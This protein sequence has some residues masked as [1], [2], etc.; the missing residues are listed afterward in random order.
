MV[1]GHQLGPVYGPLFPEPEE[2]ALTGNI[3]ASF[4]GCLAHSL[5][6]EVGQI[7]ILL[8]QEGVEAR[9]RGEDSLEVPG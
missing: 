7:Q 8:F 6:A 5:L 4:R 3:F 1:K 9:E 2:G